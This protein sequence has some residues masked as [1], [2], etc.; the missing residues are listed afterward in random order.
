M[1]CRRGAQARYLY[2]NMTDKATYFTCLTMTTASAPTVPI[3]PEIRTARRL[4]GVAGPSDGP[5][6]RGP[7]RRPDRWVRSPRPP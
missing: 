6:S 2:D 4:V 7:V 3:A 1:G 5:V